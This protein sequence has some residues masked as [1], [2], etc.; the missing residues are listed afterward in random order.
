MEVRSDAS[1]PGDAERESTAAAPF[2]MVAALQTGRDPNEAELGHYRVLHKTF[3]DP[4]H[5]EHSKKAT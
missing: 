1:S 5:D 3:A 4:L 2:A